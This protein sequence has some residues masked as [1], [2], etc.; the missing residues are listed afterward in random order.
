MN[1]ITAKGKLSKKLDFAN[2]EAKHRRRISNRIL[3][4]FAGK[5]VSQRA[6]IRKKF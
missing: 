1:Y 2:L 5:Y 3:P 4:I 6:I